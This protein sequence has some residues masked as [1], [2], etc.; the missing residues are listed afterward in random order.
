LILFDYNHDNDNDDNKDNRSIRS[1]LDGGNNT[2]ACVLHDD[3][4]TRIYSTRSFIISM[5][6][7]EDKTKHG[8]SQSSSFII[9]LRVVISIPV[10]VIVVVDIR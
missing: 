2:A 7:D 1:F 8:D 9:V 10:V 5:L 6:V 3:C 4:I